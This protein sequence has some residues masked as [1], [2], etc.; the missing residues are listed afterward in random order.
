M[1]LIHKIALIALVAAALSSCCKKHSAKPPEKVQFTASVKSYSTTSGTEEGTVLGSGEKVRIMAGSPID[2]SAVGTVSGTALLAEPPVYW[3][4]SQKES[5][6]FAAV[7]RKGTVPEATTSINCNLLNGGVHDF[8]RYDKFLTAVSTEA[9]GETVVFEFSHP[10]CK[11][12]VNV[13]DQLPDDTISKVEIKGLVMEGTIDVIAGSV[14][15][16]TAK[17][18]FLLSK[19]SEGRFAAAVMPQEASP[20]IV[21][22]T[23]KGVTYSYAS[24]S[25]TAFVPGFA[26]SAD[27]TIGPETEPDHGDAVKFSFIISPWEYGPP[28]ESS[29][30]ESDSHA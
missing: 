14:T 11:I 27:F 2:A 16:G 18:S 26:Y 3:V 17:K 6:T 10:F 19:L 4:K 24:S 7:Y 9:P 25:E 29:F 28:I 20:T 8:E 12:S 15:L 5:T 1:K 13:S 21:I 22:S 23:T 30:S